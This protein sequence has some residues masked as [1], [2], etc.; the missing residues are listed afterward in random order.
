MRSISSTR[1][2]PLLEQL[3]ALEPERPVAAVDEEAGAVDGVDHDLA[4]RLAGG[5]RDRERLRRRLRAGDDLE[6]RASAAPG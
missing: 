4:H 3:Q 6:Q 2:D 1:R 5:A